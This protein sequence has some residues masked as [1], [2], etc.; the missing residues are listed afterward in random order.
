MK[1]LKQKKEF[2]TSEG[3]ISTYYQLFLKLDNSDLL[4]PITIKEMTLKRYVLD[5]VKDEL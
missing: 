2:T 4:I 1:L 5:N 3:K